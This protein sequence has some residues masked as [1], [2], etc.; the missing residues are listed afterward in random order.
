MLKK[1]AVVIIPAML[2]LGVGTA[3]YAQVRAG[4]EIGSVGIGFA[5]DAPPRARV[6]VRGHRPSRN[7]QWVGGYWERQNDQWAWSAGRW[8]EPS[9][10]GSH[11]V[12][13]QYHHEKDGYRYE[14]GRWQH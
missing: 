9:E 10:R 4:V 7:H 12:K 5:H 13:P 3:G 6:E 1:L 11:W 2:S 8:E 14:A